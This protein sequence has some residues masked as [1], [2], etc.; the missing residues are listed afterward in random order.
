MNISKLWNVLMAIK[1]NTCKLMPRM[2]NLSPC[3]EKLYFLILP[4]INYIDQL[5]FLQSFSKKYFII[6]SY[7]VGKV[8]RN[9]LLK[10]GIHIYSHH[11]ISW[12]FSIACFT[13]QSD[14]K[15]KWFQMLIW[16][17]GIVKLEIKHTVQER[18]SGKNIN[19]GD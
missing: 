11:A 5:Y 4:M 16:T 6:L 7:S 3:M 8:S 2:L 10:I 15:F 19:R 18:N 9:I 1:Q 17:P 14:L 12:F 13:P